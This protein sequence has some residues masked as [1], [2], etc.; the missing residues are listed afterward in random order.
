MEFH[1][2]LL[3]RNLSLSFAVPSFRSSLN[4]LLLDESPSADN[5]MKFCR[6]LTMFP[7]VVGL[8]FSLD[9]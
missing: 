5:M 8:I 2:T 1:S 4:S 3:R 9:A 7:I 6:V